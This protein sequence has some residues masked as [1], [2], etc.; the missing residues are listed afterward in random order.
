MPWTSHELRRKKANEKFY[1]CLCESAGFKHHNS[2]K[3]YTGSI[4][5]LGRRLVSLPFALLPSFPP[6]LPVNV[7]CSDENRHE[8]CSTS[9]HSIPADNVKAILA[10]VKIKTNRPYHTSMR[11]RDYY[12]TTNSLWTNESEAI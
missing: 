1:K 9:G 6:A 2:Q 7:F 8:D 4:E 12:V 10:A 3:V 11:S 5:C